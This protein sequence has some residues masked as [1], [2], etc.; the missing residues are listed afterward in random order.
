MG[1]LHI[2]NLYRDQEILNFK[3]CY[4]LEK[5]HGTSAHI[6]FKKAPYKVNFFSGG[7]NYENFRKLFNEDDLISKFTELG[8]FDMVVYGEAYGGKCQGMSK[9]YGEDLRF[10][11]FDVKIGDCWLNV[12]KA[13]EIVK[14]LGLEFV[15][16]T[17]I[18]TDMESIN[19]EMYKNSEQAIRN[20]IGV[21]KE[22]NVIFI[23]QGKM[24][25][26][27]VLRPVEE[28][29]KN[30]GGRVIAKHKRDEFRET[31]T[32]RE[33]TPDKLKVLAKAKEVANEWVTRMRLTHVL[34]KMNKPSIKDTGKVIHLVTE[35]I[36]REGDG[37]IVWSNEVRKE[38]GKAIAMLFKEYINSR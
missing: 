28:Y 22:G 5:I 21:R 34:D 24:R 9:T 2:N 7:V 3:E 19:M 37:E 1:Y 11:V 16:Y 38:V 15:S 27:V 31:A 36:I 25:E 29:T 18:Q 23:E 6:G 32:K 30:N 4:A 14:L 26:G 20:G 13:E 8:I 12:P 33:I 10:V 35:D 17:K